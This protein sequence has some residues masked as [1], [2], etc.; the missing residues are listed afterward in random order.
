M[1]QLP[2]SNSDPLHSQSDCIEYL[3]K[4]R[5]LNQYPYIKQTVRPARVIQALD[6]LASLENGIY[7]QEG[8]LIDQSWLAEQRA[9]L[10]P[11][12][13]SNNLLPPPPPPTLNTTRA[14]SDQQIVAEREN[15]LE[16]IARQETDLY[17]AYGLGELR[18]KKHIASAATKV[19]VSG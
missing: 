16:R 6:Y 1:K 9:L 5:Q 11:H 14:Q 8:V 17:Y 18:A 19:S 3:W 10:A 12:H 15:T 13:I 4:K 7:K 2:R